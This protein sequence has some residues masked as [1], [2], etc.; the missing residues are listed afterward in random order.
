MNTRPEIKAVDAVKT[1]K[2]D[3]PQIYAYT[4]PDFPPKNGWIKIG[5][6][7][8]ESVETRIKEQTHTAAIRLNH[9]TLWAKAAKFPETEIYFK[10][11]Q[12]HAY[13]TRHKNVEREKGSEWFYYNGNPERAEQHFND[14]LQGDFNQAQEKLDYT[15][16]SEQQQAVDK[17]LKYAKNTTD[18]EFLWNAKPRFGKTLT[19]YD[20]ALK[21]NAQNVLIV[22]NR[23]AIAN[24]WFDD[25]EKFIAWQSDFAF[26]SESESLKNRA[27]LSRDEFLAQRLNG[28][29]KMLAFLSLQDL[30]GSRYFG[31]QFDKL[32]WVKETRWDL[33]V[34]DEAHEGVDTLKTYL[35]FD[36]IQRRFTLHLSGTPFKALAS[37]KFSEEEIYNWSYADEQKAKAEWQGEENNPYAN[38]PK[39]NMFSYQ[40]SRMITDQVNQGAEIDGENHDY[41]FD[42][43]EF[44]ATKENGKFVHEKEVK[45]WLDTL[46]RNEKYPFSTPELRNEL[47]HTFW[48]LDRVASAKALEKLLKNSFGF[49]EYEIVLAAG[50]GKNNDS[51]EQASGSSLEK[52]RQ[53]IKNGKKTIT[54]SVGQLTTGITVPEWTAVLMLSNLKSPALYMQAA[55]RAQNPWSYS[56]NGK[57]YRKENAYLFDF[58]PE[59]TLQ[60]YDDFAN[61]LAAKTAGGGGTSEEREQNIK[62]LLN[63][64]PVIAED[65]EGKMVEINAAEVLS[66]PKAIKAAEV[67]K[68]G[69]LSNLLFAN[70]SN[71]FGAVNSEVLE[72]LEQ[73]PIAKEE[74]IQHGGE[75]DTQGVEV[76]SEGNAIVA[77]SIV[78]SETQARFGEKQY[79]TLTQTVTKTLE[80][81][82]TAK[83]LSQAVAETLK[84]QMA[85]QVSDLAKE[86]GVS[87]KFAQQIVERS[88]NEIK[89]EIER[90]EKQAEI[91]RF[92]LEKGY[93]QA[94][95]NAENSAKVAEL[96]AEY[97]AKRTQLEENQQQKLTEIVQTKAKEITQTVTESVLV[98]AETLKKAEVESDIRDRLRGFSRTIPAFLM[99]YGNEQTTLANFDQIIP[100]NVFQEVTGITLAQFR[101]LRDEYHFF[102]EP[103]FNE[104]VKEFLAKRS[105]LAN[106]F[107]ENQ[108]ED[109]FS[110]IPPQK[111][112][113]IFTPRAVVQLMLDKLEEENADIFQNSETTFCD[114]Y[115]KSG[116]F[117]TEIVKRLFKGLACK[118][119]NETERLQHILTKQIYGFAP[120]EIIFNIAK[121][122][123]FN[124]KTAEICSKN[125]VCLDTTPFAMG[126]SGENFSEKCKKLFGEENMKFDVVVGNPP[127]Q[128]NNEDNNRD[129]PIYH[130][131]YELAEKSANKY[132]L[133]SPARF[134]FNAGQTPKQ[135]NEK[136]LNNE[137]IKVIF[138]NQKSAHLFPNTD[139]KGGL[140]ILYYDNSKKIGPIETFTSFEDLNSIMSKV[141]H[142]NDFN[143]IN[144]ILFVRS[145]YKF[146]DLM[147]TD[148]PELKGRVKKNEEKSMGSNVFDRYPEI[149]SDVRLSENQIQIYGR[150]NNTRV[151]KFVDKKYI[152]YPENLEKWKVF[153]PKSNGSGAIGEILSTPMIGTPMIG[154]TQTFISFGSLNTQFEAEALLKYLKTKFSRAMLG[155]K[156]ITQDNATKEI[157]SKVPL[158][159]FTENS[160]IDWTKSIAEIDQQLYQKYGLDE[161]EIAFIE[162]KVR[163]ME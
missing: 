121:N 30:K 135:W 82:D 34:I 128:E 87:E 56:E 52:V 118:I 62:E 156:K 113:Q 79:K 11:H 148:H 58:A 49:S 91:E 134:L 40:M 162:E 107:D 24:S 115:V 83:S 129:N 100:D 151:Y 131:F 7:D 59:R 125:L 144:K 75:I 50:D 39:L 46:T 112:N 19:T 152:S 163:E 57:H 89:T 25:F 153:V 104:S 18:G 71:I 80:N 55:F 6:T 13:L 10:D 99:A 44:F 120:S 63:F 3:F 130:H 68:R 74:K 92:E 12:F 23:P 161:K 14:F 149:F 53:A 97:Q 101:V 81:P 51:D 5:Y 155:I 47:K 123:M 64:F 154:H 94:V 4:L 137:N 140:S 111:T 66:I 33:L 78:I 28:K 17:T 157:W 69:F 143:S 8:R 32:S 27:T 110:Y 141:T 106:Y 146:T 60:I 65:S 133:I 9:H 108:L 31:G 96:T 22:T 139:V 20:F 88:A 109:I 37:G 95:E 61:N 150:Q 102:D 1:T 76:D 16:R 98:Q 41:A 124:G 70:I 42:L 54:L 145:S 93:E 103:T 85:D 29:K 114:L 116:L 127:Y 86:K 105:L 38:L 158:Q 21:L 84:T 119:P 26:V 45:K 67:V 160:D 147:L 132:C 73:L 90:A 77:P 126:T 48:L 117:L 15:L 136:M 2:Q 122:F 35:A 43:N 142:N 36:N 138:F 159:D 72:I